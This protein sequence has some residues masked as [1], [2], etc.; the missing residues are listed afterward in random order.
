[1][2]SEHL[3]SAFA[4]LGPADT[5]GAVV[6]NLHSSHPRLARPR[7]WRAFLLLA[8]SFAVAPHLAAAE[9]QLVRGPYLQMPGPST[10]T[11]RWRTDQPGLGRVRYG[12]QPLT[13]SLVAEAGATVTEHSVTVTNLQPDTLYYYSVGVGDRVLTNGSGFRFRTPAVTGGT[14]PFRVWVLGDCGYTNFS[15]GPVRDA[16]Y[17]FTTNRPVDLWLMLGD[18]AY[19]GG[20]DGLY[21][22]AVFNTYPTQLRQ[23]PLFSTIGNQETAGSAMPLPTIA[24][25]DIFT[26]PMNGELGGVPS[27]SERYF[28]FDYGNAHFVCLDSMSSSRATNSPMYVWLKSDLEANTNE[29]LIVFFH[30]PPYSKGSNDSDVQAPQIEMRANFVPL[31]EEHG[32][33]LV[34]CGHS[35][36]YE[37]TWLMDGHYGLSGTFTDSMKVDGGDGHVGAGGS[38][39]YQKA[40][41]GAAAHEGAVYVVAGSGSQVNHTGTLNHPATL[42]SAFVLGSVALDVHANRIDVRFIRETGAIDDD[43]TLVKG[44]SPFRILRVQGG[45]GQFA[46]RWTAVADRGYRVEFKAALSDPGWQDVSGLLRADGPVLGWSGAVPSPATAGGFFRVW[47]AED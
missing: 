32:V 26:F 47:S 25:F 42:R 4:L 38:G 3:H 23:T 29:W 46:L 36:S 45:G 44:A 30:H 19:T 17:Q 27:G 2:E 14:R 20:T 10:M 31:L 22:N 37:R 43:F 13:L 35:H 15:A 33:D 21:Q 11:V 1:M 34:L 8:F 9:A 39:A 24:Y 12:T 28:S 6:V 40:T 7:G 41:L 5:L 16:F 18:N